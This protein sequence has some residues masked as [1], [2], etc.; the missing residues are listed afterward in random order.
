VKEKLMKIRSDR[1]GRILKRS[2][3]GRVDEYINYEKHKKEL[4]TITTSSKQ[5][6]KNAFSPR[7]RNNT[8][9]ANF[10]QTATSGNP[11]T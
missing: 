11:F 2:L 9:A 8:G 5:N 7:R 4:K 6:G 3:I 10:A 1:D